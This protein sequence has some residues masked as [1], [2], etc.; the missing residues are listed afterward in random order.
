MS[1]PVFKKK[2]IKTKPLEINYLRYVFTKVS[3]NLIHNGFSA[4]CFLIFVLVNATYKN[5]CIRF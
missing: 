4:L 2:K 3:H 5:E 1:L